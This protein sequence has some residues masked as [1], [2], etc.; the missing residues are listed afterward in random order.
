MLQ[1]QRASAGSGKTYTLAKKY[2]WYLITT[3]TPDGHRRLRDSGSLAESLRSILAVTFTNKATNE[4]KQRI[5]ARLSDIALASEADKD[6]SLLKS[7]P[8]LEEFM[9]RLGVT[10]AEISTACSD[11]LRIVLNRY[12][13]FNIS[14]IDSFFQRVLRTFAYETDLNDNYQ[15]EL[16]NDYVASVGLDTT[17]EQ[18]DSSDNANPEVLFWIRTIINE[19]YLDEGKAN[20]NPFARSSARYSLNANL[21]DSLKCLDKEDF[22]EIKAELDA[23]LEENPN[24]RDIYIKARQEYM[25]YV[26]YH[27]DQC[28]RLARQFLSRAADEDKEGLI[29]KYATNAVSKVIKSKSADIME[30]ADTLDKYTDFVKKGKNK[31][32][33]ALADDLMATLSP[34]YEQLRAAVGEMK[35]DPVIIH[36]KIYGKQFPYLGLV[37]QVRHNINEYLRDN[38]IVELGDTSAILSSIIADE[39]TPFIYERLGTRLQHYLIDEFQDTSRL[40]WGNLRPLVAESLAGAH[41]NLII[42]DAKQSIYRFR[43]ADPTLIIHTVRQTFGES[44]KLSGDSKEDNTNWRSQ[45]NIVE[46]NNFFF[47]YASATL[48]PGT[49]GRL[50]FNDIYSNVAQ[51]PHHRQNLGYVSIN[52]PETSLPSAQGQATDEETEEETAYYASFGPLVKSLV[53]RGYRQKDIAFLVWRNTDGVAL[54]NGLISYNTTLPP[55]EPLIQFISEQSLLVSNSEAVATIVSVLE[56]I[57]EGTRVEIRTGEEARRKGVADW[58]DIACNFNFFVR[59]HPELTRS[60][61]ITEFLRNP[62]MGDSISDMLSGMQTVALPAIVEAVA[63]NFLTDET[64]RTDA[65][66]IAAFQDLVL[67]FCEGTSTD[68]AAFLKWWHDKG[69]G[70]SIT[71]PEEMDAVRIMTVHKSKGLEF[72]VVILPRVDTVLTREPKEWRWVAPYPVVDGLPPYL[73]VTNGKNLTGTIHEHLYHESADLDMLDRLNSVYV[74]FTRAVDELHIY[75]PGGDA[76]KDKEGHIRKLLRD[77]VTSPAEALGKLPHATENIDSAL[78]LHTETDNDGMEYYATGT[79]GP[80]TTK[81]DREESELFQTVDEYRVQPVTSLLAYHGKRTPDPAVTE[82]LFAGADA[83]NEDTPSEEEAAGLHLERLE[84]MDPRSA[85]NLLHSV[86][87]DVERAED[88]D[89]A[90]RRLRLDGTVSHDDALRME[91]M[92]RMA[93]NAT[94][95]TRG[96]FDGSRRVMTE[97]SLLTR[98]TT[99]RRPDRIMVSSD[100]TAT[101]VDYKFGS[102]TLVR[103]HTRDVKHYMHLLMETGLFRRVEGYVWYMAERHVVSLAPLP[104]SEVLETV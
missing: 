30:V 40:Q 57:N 54:I 95:Q 97:R 60:Q 94:E 50:D 33:Q 100:G 1:L 66:F 13:D 42:G 28:R 72:P 24:L 84:E 5:I 2:I 103:R 45:R 55:E 63:S 27:A 46:F 59:R 76:G 22:K 14:T 96:W 37:Q 62:D 79:P 83:E 99:T 81:E 88:L 85:G 48:N 31:A 80:Y 44:C 15:V 32:Q 3:D 18:I 98:R 74:A 104:E 7:T 65:A 69:A 41:D 9:T 43:N 92:L 10:A 34:D 47:A 93:I 77:A 91:D 4:M 102:Q 26:D 16:D 38:N 29:K 73:P 25:R 17:L 21:M 19:Q 52:F 78:S 8:Y 68:I 23:Y 56:A 58:R 71:S 90:V 11:A 67:N 86:M 75:S 61:Q 35:D 39:D 82:S 101:V 70:K 53:R 12:S 6:P 64:R 89:K 36:W 51:Y 87:Q 20:W 49:P